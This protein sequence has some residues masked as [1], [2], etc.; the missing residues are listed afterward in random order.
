M[1]LAA[2]TWATQ[3]APEATATSR[4]A[5]SARSCSAVWENLR[6]WSRSR[7]TTAVV[8]ARRRKRMTTRSGSSRQ[9]T[10]R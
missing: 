8:R 1:A 5:R 7:A 10:A 6:S 9:P 2:S 3:R 4:S